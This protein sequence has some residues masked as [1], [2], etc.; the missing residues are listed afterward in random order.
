[1]IVETRFNPSSWKQIE[2]RQ[3][4]CRDEHKQTNASKTEDGPESRGNLQ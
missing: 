2:F 1:M 3:N 4:V